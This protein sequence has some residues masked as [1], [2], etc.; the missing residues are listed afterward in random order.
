MSVTRPLSFLFVILAASAYALNGQPMP[1]DKQISIESPS[2]DGKFAFRISYGEDL[3]TID[4]I[5]AK[6]EKVVFH[7]AD[8]NESQTY[9]HVLWAPDSKRFALMTRLGHPIQGV[10]VYAKSDDTFHEI[11]LPELPEAKI[12]EKLKH[13]KKFP[14]IAGLDWQEAKEWNSDGSLVV[15]ID[16]MIDGGDDGSLRATRTVVLGF[17]KSGKA[18]IVKSTIKYA[19]EKD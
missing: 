6:S 7:V 19:A 1:G 16:T 8:T 10:S 9:W 12:P 11:K 13:G 18:R 2:P 14:H 4:L 15:N 5:D 17:D 3:R